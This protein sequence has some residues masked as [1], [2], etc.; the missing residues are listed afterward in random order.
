MVPPDPV[1]KSGTRHV[2]PAGTRVTPAGGTNTTII[3]AGTRGD[4]NSDGPKTTWKRPPLAPLV[5]RNA[6]A[7]L[8]AAESFLATGPR[9]REGGDAYQVVAIV[10]AETLANPDAEP[11]KTSVLAGACHLENGPSISA[12]VARRLAC[13][14]TAVAALLDSKD[15]PLHIGRHTRV[16]N[17]RLRRALKIRDGHC[18]FPGCDKKGFLE[19]H[20]VRHWADGGATDI[21]N[22]LLLCKHHHGAVHEG[23]Y[24]LQRHPDA[25]VLVHRPDGTA[26]VVDPTVIDPTYTI[27]EQHRR[28]GLSI[29]HRTHRC[30]WEGRGAG[31][32]DILCYLDRKTHFAE[33]QRERER[34]QGERNDRERDQD[35]R[36]RQPA[37]ATS[38]AA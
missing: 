36:D 23:G 3:T 13:D 19:V 9:G 20:H 10:D 17:R 22:T 30:E 18:Q 5:T 35:G 8:L 31:I 6:D 29:D 21:E 37:T 27:E 2:K 32:S 38:F 7:L 4:A 11:E 12:H 26:L 14:C 34:I 15:D 28:N 33:Q 24:T 1:D 25:T 16:V